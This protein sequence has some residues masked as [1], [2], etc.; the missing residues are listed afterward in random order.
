M[1]A[2]A[3]GVPYLDAV[4]EFG[5]SS[6]SLAGSLLIAH[7]GLLDP[8]FRKSVLFLSTNDPDE[9]SF[10]V[11]L[12]RPAG[13]TVA[14][15]LPKQHLGNLGNVPVL[16]GGPVSADQLLFA[17]FHWDS[18]EERM[19]CRHHLMLDDAREAADA[20]QM[21]V[22]AFVGYAG[23]SK[24]QLES[25]LAQRAWLVGKPSRDAL[26]LSRSATLWRDTISGF[27]PWFRLVAEAPEDISRN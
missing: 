18:D 25:E 13:R 12:N 21:I 6:L 19:E 1:L 23:W 4:R 2:T 9:G 26:R 15:L 22:R 10:G 16:V 20:K 3:R 5:S 17:A 14:D 8:N 7:P 11:V 24:G 27:G